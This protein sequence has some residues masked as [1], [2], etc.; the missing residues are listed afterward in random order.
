MRDVISSHLATGRQNQI[1]ILQ[2]SLI[3]FMV[4]QKKR[5]EGGRGVAITVSQVK[6]EFRLPSNGL[7]M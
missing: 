4:A 3:Y 5:G 7:F 6:N 2:K 1:H